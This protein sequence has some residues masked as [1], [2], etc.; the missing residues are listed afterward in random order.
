MDGI[1][2]YPEQVQS[3]TGNC[4][5]ILDIDLK[6]RTSDVMGQ[7]VGGRLKIRASIARGL[8]KRTTDYWG[9]TPCII[10]F[11]GS[12]IEFGSAWFDDRLPKLSGGSDMLTEQ[13]EVYLLPV[14][15]VVDSAEGL[16]LCANMKKGEFRRI[17]T[18][19]I[20]RYDQPNWDNFRSVMKGD[21]NMQNYEERLDHKNGYWFASDYTYTINLI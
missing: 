15:D 4:I 11:P 14:I 5:E 12:Q 20:G 19:E 9:R 2:S 13:L 10:D 3:A 7:V 21:E 16:L 18:F 8:L 6:H 17:G 1:V